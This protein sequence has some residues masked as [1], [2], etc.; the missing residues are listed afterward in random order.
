MCI[1]RVAENLLARDDAEG[2][3]GQACPDDMSCLSE[4][5]HHAVWIHSCEPAVHGYGQVLDCYMVKDTGSSVG[6]SFTRRSPS[7]FPLP[8]YLNTPINKSNT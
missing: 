8:H 2:Q 7:R 3:T 1:F 4:V 6:C 5:L